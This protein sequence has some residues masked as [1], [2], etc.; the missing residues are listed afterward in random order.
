MNPM[1]WGA[2]EKPPQ[3]PGPDGLQEPGGGSQGHPRLEAAW[4]TEAAKI[5]VRNLGAEELVGSDL[6]A[7]CRLEQDICPSG[8][9][10]LCLFSIQSNAEWSHL[11]FLPDVSTT[12]NSSPFHLFG[13]PWKWAVVGPH[14]LNTVSPGLPWGVPSLLS[15][16]DSLLRS[17]FPSPALASTSLPFSP[18]IPEGICHHM[19]P[20][21]DDHWAGLDKGPHI[22]I[23]PFQPCAL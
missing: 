21:S 5:C 6:Q 10:P 4:D 23:S 2:S 7:G 17:P 22:L 1:F 12:S 3:Q 11:A 19:D 16:P 14:I 13:Y 18:L 15:P 20:T 8:L 9:G